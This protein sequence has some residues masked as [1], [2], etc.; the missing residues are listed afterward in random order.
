MKVGP[1]SLDLLS[2]LDECGRAAS[3]GEAIRA[4]T[5][6]AVSDFDHFRERRYQD[7]GSSFVYLTFVHVSPKLTIQSLD[8]GHRVS[9]TAM[10]E[11]CGTNVFRDWCLKS[12]FG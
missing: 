12:A 8:N 1:G 3:C 9:P 7:A 6:D 5:A 2:L 4:W 10:L 11:G